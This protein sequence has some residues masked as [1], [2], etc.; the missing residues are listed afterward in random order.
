MVKA[1][2]GKH[3]KSTTVSSSHST[4]P[5]TS[6]ATA[7]TTASNNVPLNPSDISNLETTNAAASLASKMSSMSLKG[8]NPP[9]KETNLDALSWLRECEMRQTASGEPYLQLEYQEDDDLIVLLHRFLEESTGGIE[10]IDAIYQIW[11]Q[12]V[13][14]TL[15][16]SNAVW[17][18]ETVTARDQKNMKDTLKSARYKIHFL[19]HHVT[20]SILTSPMPKWM[21][22]R[23]RVLDRMCY[24]TLQLVPRLAESCPHHPTDIRL[25]I[26]HFEGK[27]FLASVACET[28]DT[29]YDY[30]VTIDPNRFVPLLR[31]CAMLDIL[32]KDWNMLGGWDDILKGIEAK[33]CAS[34]TSATTVIHRLPSDTALHET[35]TIL[36]NARNSMQCKFFSV[37]FM[38]YTDDQAPQ[39]W[40]YFPK[41][42]APACANIET[43]EH[44][45]PFRCRKCWYFHYCSASCQEYCD[46]IMGLHPK[47]CHDTPPSKAAL[48]RKET[49]QHLGWMSPTNDDKGVVATTAE[50]IF[51]HACGI[52]EDRSVASTPES[53]SSMRRCM[54]CQAA[55][56]CSRPCQEW[57]WRVGGHRAICKPVVTA[58]PTP[59]PMKVSPVLGPTLAN[60]N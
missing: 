6:T 54:Q 27:E 9:T 35:T 18:K 56:Y 25:A 7:T 55:S 60:L 37:R 59:S 38:K 13:L 28:W 15:L 49:E 52:P 32:D 57:D 3:K 1:K 40:R 47:F 43:S 33:C 12:T 41:C 16:Q 24:N 8:A 39:R 48:C 22:L 17:K 19:L 31:R 14:S 36:R 42:S 34:G 21:A 2:K 44:P 11:Q 4:T 10:I 26:L 51:C 58:T 50:M 30:A 45:H 23:D 53:A 5:S 29:L 20:G 46:N